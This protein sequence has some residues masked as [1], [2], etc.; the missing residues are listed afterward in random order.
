MNILSIRCGV[1][2]N[3]GNYEFEKL[4]IEAAPS[5][6]QT[7]EELLKEVSKYLDETLNGGDTAGGSR[8][9]AA[10]KSDTDPPLAG[11]KKDRKSTSK[12][13]K[14]SKKD[15]TITKAEEAETGGRAVGDTSDGQ[16]PPWEGGG[17]YD[18]AVPFDHENPLRASGPAEKAKPAKATKKIARVVFAEVVASETLE[19]LLARFN[20]FRD[21]GLGFRALLTKKEWDKTINVIQ[22]C[23]KALTTSE[24]DANVMHDLVAAINSERNTAK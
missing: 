16:G 20:G 17:A 18:D 7:S 22:D 2:R 5:D 8:K 14:K 13:V 1:T 24:S 10:K 23:Y 19:T 3:L 9:P 15:T 21:P 12:K 6:G 11:G 4:E